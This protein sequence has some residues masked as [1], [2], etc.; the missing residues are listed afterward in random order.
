MQLTHDPFLCTEFQ[1]LILKRTVL[2]DMTW[3]II[4][5]LIQAFVNKSTAEKALQ[6]PSIYDWN[7]KSRMCAAN[8]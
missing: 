4:F 7:Y 6:S 3:P 5:C 2:K 8:I 1:I